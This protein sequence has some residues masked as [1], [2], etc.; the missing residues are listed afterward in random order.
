MAQ[1]AW[2]RHK[3][4]RE[5]PWKDFQVV[6][7]KALKAQFGF[8]EAVR[9]RKQYIEDIWEEFGA[10]WRGYNAEL[11]GADLGSKSKFSRQPTEFEYVHRLIPDPAVDDP[12]AFIPIV[13]ARVWRPGS[14]LYCEIVIMPYNRPLFSIH[15]GAATSTRKDYWDIARTYKKLIKYIETRGRKKP[16]A[17]EIRTFGRM[18]ANACNEL[19]KAGRRRTY[20]NVAL[21]MDKDVKTI[22]SYLK[23]YLHKSL[24][25]Y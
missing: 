22:K 23:E 14:S 11:T 20:E 18:L 21:Q 1:S 24:N 10:S 9:L 25:D 6:A 5:L 8:T 2:E 13:R 15:G 12:D 16:S 4:W 17:E 7:D 3:K 19:R